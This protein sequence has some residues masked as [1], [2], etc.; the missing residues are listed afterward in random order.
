[1]IKHDLRELTKLYLERECDV[2]EPTETDIDSQI[3]SG[4]EVFGSREKLYQVL[5]TYFNVNRN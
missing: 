5:R 2:S 4:V 3:S 1:M